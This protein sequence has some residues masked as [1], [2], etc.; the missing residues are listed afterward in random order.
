M[1]WEDVSFYGEKGDGSFLEAVHFL[2]KKA[3]FHDHIFFEYFILFLPPPLPTPCFRP[4]KKKD[5]FKLFPCHCQALTSFAPQRLQS[6]RLNRHFIFYNS[7]IEREAWKTSV[8]WRWYNRKPAAIFHNS[9]N[10]I[11]KKGQLYT[12]HRENVV[13]GDED[14]TH[15]LETKKKLLLAHGRHVS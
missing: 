15:A 14:P 9:W 2:S 5:G 8:V 12:R 7:K 1:R 11:L 3:L 10:R 4:Q 6:V 13:W